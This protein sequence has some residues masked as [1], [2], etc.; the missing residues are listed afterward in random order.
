MSQVGPG[1]DPVGFSVVSTTPHA[2]GD[3][4]VF[5]VEGTAVALANV[6]GNLYAFDDT[7][8]H[9]E[10]PLSEGEFDGPIVTCPCHRSRFDLRTGDVLNGPA[11][12]P[13]RVRRLVHEAERLLV[14]H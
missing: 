13:I 11:T 5:D 2:G 6:D 9:R 3:V 14:E 4:I 1:L 10:C 7:C 8:T 12:L